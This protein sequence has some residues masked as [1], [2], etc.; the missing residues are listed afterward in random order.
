MQCPSRAEALQRVQE[1]AGQERFT[2]TRNARK[3]AR[4][5]G[6]LDGDICDCLCE[7]ELHE[8]EDV[9]WSDWQDHPGPILICDTAFA[10]EVSTP[11][12]DDISVKTDRLYV[13]VQLPAEGDEDSDLV[14]LSFKLYGS[15]R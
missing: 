2:L 15:P 6:Y 7:I 10:L 4:N 12:E 1:L 9:V 14:I 8:C 13:K 11:D 3:D 5:L